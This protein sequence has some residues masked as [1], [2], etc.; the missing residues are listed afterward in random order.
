M[1]RRPALARR[2][3]GDEQP[4]T[5]RAV[6][7]V[8]GARRRRRSRRRPGPGRGDRVVPAPP[9]THRPGQ[10]DRFGAEPQQSREPAFRGT[11]GPRGARRKRRRPGQARPPDRTRRR[12]ERSGSAA[13]GSVRLAGSRVAC[14]LSGPGPR[15]LGDASRSRPWP[16]RRGA[17]RRRLGH[18]QNHVRRGHR[19]GA[20]PG[21]VRGRPVHGGR[22]IRRRDGKE[23]G[24]DFQRSRRGQRGLALRRGGCHLRQALRCQRRARPVREHRKRLPV[25]ADGVF[26]RPGDPVHQSAREHR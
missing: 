7:A 3:A 10:P 16:R 22:Q 4:G 17:L 19:R 9:G 23:P 26:R 15:R 11:P 2:C 12:L 24:A 18:R 14:R 21:L 1:A 13:A 25:A 8:F 6:A 20:G 5:G